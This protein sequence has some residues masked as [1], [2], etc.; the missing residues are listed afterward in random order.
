MAKKEPLVDVSALDKR[1]VMDIRYATTKNFTGKVLYPAARCLLLASVAKKLPK[2]QAYLDKHAKGMRLMFK[3]CYRP[4][5]AQ[6]KMW[7]I[8]K[9]TPKARYVANPKRGSIHNYG[10]AV[11]LTLANKMGHELDM[12]TP[13]LGKLTQA[14]VDNRRLLRRAMVHAGFKQLSIEWW[15]FDGIVWRAL[16]GR[17][18][19]RRP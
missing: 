16:K 15:H 13:F 3:D 9:G 14:Q 12:G 18:P 5:S 11:D 1:W 7:E 4:L 8:V 17:S 19:K 6:K 2:A 10:A